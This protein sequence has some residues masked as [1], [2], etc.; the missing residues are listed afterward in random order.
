MPACLGLRGPRNDGIGV[1]LHEDYSSPYRVT[2]GDRAAM[3]LRRPIRMS[4][5]DVL[6]LECVPHAF[7]STDP[8]H[9]GR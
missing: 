5:C 9:G 4:A 3:N 6:R 8:M 7:R 2:G 1:S